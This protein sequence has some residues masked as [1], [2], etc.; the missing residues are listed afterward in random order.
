MQTWPWLNSVSHNTQLDIHV[1]GDVEGEEGGLKEG[2]SDQYALCT[3]M[4][5]SNSTFS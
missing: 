5:F 2:D 1:S 4:K 3:W